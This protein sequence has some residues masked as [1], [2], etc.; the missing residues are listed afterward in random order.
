M[1]YPFSLLFSQAPTSFAPFESPPIFKDLKAYFKHA[2]GRW[3]ESTGGPSASEVHRPLY[4]SGSSGTKLTVMPGDENS[5]TLLIKGHREI[6]NNGG[7]VEKEIKIAFTLVGIQNPSFQESVLPK[8]EL[9][10]VY[11]V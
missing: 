2:D 1:A 5:R 10:D 11:G 9:K 4:R 8:R 3:V 6:N 7:G